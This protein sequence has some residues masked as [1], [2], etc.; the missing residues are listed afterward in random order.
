MKLVALCAA[1]AMTTTVVA[2]QEFFF[3]L[4]TV[5]KVDG[6][7]A[8][9]NVEKSGSASAYGI[10]ATS[11]YPSEEA[12]PSPSGGSS[13]P[14][15]D[16]LSSNYE[17]LLPLMNSPENIKSYLMA[18]KPKLPGLLA[19]LKEPNCELAII[20]MVS[21]LPNNVKEV[22]MIVIELMQSSLKMLNEEASPLSSEDT[23]SNPI[24]APP[25][26]RGV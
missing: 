19:Q 16:D 20:G 9:D 2:K 11:P 1:L 12:T 13:C 21:S 23:S 15:I 24:E 5:D 14:L 18:L 26:L 7:A 4:P 3:K 6:I 17:A 25:V 22:V 10:D 8:V